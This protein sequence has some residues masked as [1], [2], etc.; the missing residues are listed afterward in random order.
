M[1]L[2]WAYLGINPIKYERAIACMIS[3][4]RIE[5]TMYELEGLLVTS[6]E[7]MLRPS[8][9]IP[10][11]STPTRVPIRVPISYWKRG[12]LSSREINDY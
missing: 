3:E 12:D 9:A 6:T 7:A 8:H 4:A 10:L 11:G 2:I 5:Y 1:V